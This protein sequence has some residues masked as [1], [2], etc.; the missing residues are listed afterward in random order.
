MIRGTTERSEQRDD[1]T[2]ILVA[3][4]LRAAT[5]R[6]TIVVSRQPSLPTSRHE[7]G[8]I[9][10]RATFSPDT[11]TLPGL[12]NALFVNKPGV[13][14]WPLT[15]SGEVGHAFGL[16][17]RGVLRYT[18]LRQP[19]D[20]ERHS[21][22]KPHLRGCCCSCCSVRCCCD[23]PR[24]CCYCCCSATRHERRESATFLATP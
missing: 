14:S 15:N 13:R 21:L 10:G 20:G 23:S 17:Y 8:F 2:N 9:F 12:P 18:Q 6:S 3:A 24:A 19:R 5:A 7:T 1:A 11:G 16:S 22:S 4:C